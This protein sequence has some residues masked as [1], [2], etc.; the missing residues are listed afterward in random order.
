MY[1]NVETNN[2]TNE[3]KKIPEILQIPLFILVWIYDLCFNPHNHCFLSIWLAFL[4]NETRKNSQNN[5]NS[6]KKV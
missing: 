4:K 6:F 2:Q 5:K 1:W 3:F